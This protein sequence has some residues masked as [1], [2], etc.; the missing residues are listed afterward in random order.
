[1]TK[2]LFSVTAIIINKMTDHLEK[3]LERK[4]KYLLDIVSQ[5]LIIIIF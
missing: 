5:A 3:D 4:T 2:L 1:M